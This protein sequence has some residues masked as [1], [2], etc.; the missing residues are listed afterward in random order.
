M[1]LLF[2]LVLLTIAVVTLALAAIVYFALDSAPQIQRSAD[3]SP[4]SIERAKRIIEQNDPRRLKPGVRRT[5]AIGEGDLDLAANYLA[6]QYANGGARVELK[7]QTALLGASL[8]VPLPVRAYVNVHAEVREGPSLPLLESLRVGQ[9]TVPGWAAQWLIPRLLQFAAPEA[10]LQ[11]IAGVIQK[12]SLSESRLALTYTW[13]ADLPGKVRAVLVSAEDRERL[14]AYHERLLATSSSVPEP[15]PSLMH[16]LAPLFGLAGER[17]A[18]GDAVAE[19]RAAILTLALYIN[20]R[21]IRAVLPEA[22]GWPKPRQHAVLLNGRPD[23]AKHFI[24]S[25]ALAAKAGGPLSDAVGLY[26]ELADAREGSGFS[27]SDLAA[28]RAGTRFGEHAAGSDTAR[29]LQ[30]RLRAGVSEPDI[31]P[32][33][34]DLPEF[35]P[36]REFNRRF[37]G[38]DGPAY[39]RMI[40]KIESRITALPLYR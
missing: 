19:N 32:I 22:E 31:A 30:K 36:E 10:D 6:R 18:G 37:G 26:K 3:I 9:L 29:G 23:L 14:R 1:R 15:R 5:I 13:Q 16:F 28:D 12:V 40:A 11:A 38:I 25:A 39:N 4:A 21:D 2:K 24:V 33:T 17:S 20:G 34:H 8:R 35:M 27:F 7:S